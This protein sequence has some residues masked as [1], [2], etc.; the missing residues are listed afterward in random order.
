[1]SGRMERVEVYLVCECG[2]PELVHETTD[3]ED[4]LSMRDLLQYLEEN[5]PT[6]SSIRI[7]MH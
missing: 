5:D 4:A 7:V 2:E 6:G 3:I 1:M